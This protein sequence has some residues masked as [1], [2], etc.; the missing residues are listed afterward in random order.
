MRHRLYTR[1]DVTSSSRLVE[2]HVVVEKGYVQVEKAYVHVDR[3]HLECL[4]ISREGL[5]KINLPHTQVP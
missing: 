5:P 4:H 1:L 2:P 3:S